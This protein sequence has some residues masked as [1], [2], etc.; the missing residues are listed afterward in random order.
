MNDNLRQPVSL[1]EARATSKP[2]AMWSPFLAVAGLAVDFA[3]GTVAGN[4]RVQSFG[5]VAALEALAMPLAALGQHLLSSEH[6]ATAT[7]AALARRR[8]DRSGV[9]Q[10]CLW[11]LIATI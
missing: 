5:A 1:K 11:S 8:H 9:D 2:V 3:V 4:D 6:H 7:R 10:R